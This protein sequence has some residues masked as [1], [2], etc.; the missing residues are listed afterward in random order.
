VVGVEHVDNKEIKVLLQ[1]YDVAFGAVEDLPKDPEV[2]GGGGREAGRKG[3][4]LTLMMAG[5]AS[6]RPMWSRMAPRTSGTTRSI[7]QSPR[8]SPAPLRAVIWARQRKP[9]NVRV[10]W[11]SRSTARCVACC[12]SVSTSASR[13][14]RVSMKVKAV[15]AKLAGGTGV[16]GLGARSEAGYI[17]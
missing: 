2:S 6:T 5:L 11:C 15:S 10:L 3:G 7:T 12:S 17:G 8:T 13:P 1:P 9:A 4:R 14:A 16:H